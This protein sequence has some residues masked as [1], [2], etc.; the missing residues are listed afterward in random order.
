[1]TESDLAPLNVLFVRRLTSTAGSHIL[2]EGFFRGRLP[3]TQ[4][5]SATGRQ[6][7]PGSA[8]PGKEP[9]AEDVSAKAILQEVWQIFIGKITIV[10][11]N[12]NRAIYCT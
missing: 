10:K 2:N 11:S 12:A 8:L 3:I 1:M 9:S 6:E 7:P 4:I 5:E